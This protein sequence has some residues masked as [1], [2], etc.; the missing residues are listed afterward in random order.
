MNTNLTQ[1][2]I[3]TIE[4][5]K[6][7]LGD[8][9]DFA[10]EQTP[11]LIREFLVWRFWEHFILAVALAVVAVIAWVWVARLINKGSKWWSDWDVFAG[12]LTGLAVLISV[13]S[14]VGAI[15]NGLQVVKIKVAPRVYLVEFAA[16]TIKGKP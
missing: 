9:F 8:G 11:L 6:K 14:T 3:E 1:V 2:V 10:K 15:H 5:S 4:E 13:I 12:L 7:V 16:D